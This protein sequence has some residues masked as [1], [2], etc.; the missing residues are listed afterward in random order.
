MNLKD[1]DLDAL[2]AE[3]RPLDV[4]SG[5]RERF[6]RLYRSSVVNALP[7]TRYDGD[8]DALMGVFRSMSAEQREEV[9][10][11]L[12]ERQMSDQL[13][14]FT[15]KID[16][17]ITLRNHQQAYGSASDDERGAEALLSGY[18]REQHRLTDK[19]LTM[20][21][22]RNKIAQKRVLLQRSIKSS[23]PARA[24][25]MAKPAVSPTGAKPTSGI[26]SRDGVRPDV[27]PASGPGKKAT[28]SAGQV[29]ETP[30]P[31]R[32]TPSAGSP[33]PQPTRSAHAQQGAGIPTGPITP[34]RRVAAATPNAVPGFI[35]SAYTTVPPPGPFD[36][37]DP[38]DAALQ[39]HYLAVFED[40]ANWIGGEPEPSKEPTALSDVVVSGRVNATTTAHASLSA[41][42]APTTSARQVTPSRSAMPGPRVEPDAGA[43]VKADGAAL[44]PV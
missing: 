37:N 25:S 27:I 40:T 29:S 6:E 7:W 20:Q 11:D 31:A 17:L 38:V 24:K 23:S 32:S 34:K 44:Q 3:G 41:P 5:L 10:L 21:E 30:S 8:Q 28:G 35:P 14:H 2:D 1:V 26:P 36:P 33:P 43:A 9:A 39:K 12:V 22:R 16:M 18:L 19:L 42:S 15:C 13:F 4:D